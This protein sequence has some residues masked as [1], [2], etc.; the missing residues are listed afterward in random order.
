MP[1]LSELF[2]LTRTDVRSMTVADL[3]PYLDALPAMRERAH[4]ADE[5]HQWNTAWI[6]AQANQRG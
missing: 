6:K 3:Q 1:E 5:A 2:G 4:R